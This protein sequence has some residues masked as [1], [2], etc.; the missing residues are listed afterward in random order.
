MWTRTYDDRWERSDR[1][2]VTMTARG[3]WNACVS[4]PDG[5]GGTM[6]R[7]VSGR[8]VRCAPPLLSWKTAEEA[9]AAVD[10]RKPL[11]SQNPLA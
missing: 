11:P 10:A 5:V 9:M 2:N 4:G 8:G 3:R 1:S 6:L 7:K